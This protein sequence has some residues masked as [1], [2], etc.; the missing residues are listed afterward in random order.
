LNVFPIQLPAL[1]DRPEDVP[2]LVRYLVE[3]CAEK[4]GKKI[5]TIDEQTLDLLRAYDWPG[6][7]RE[8]QNVI[9]RAVIL[10]DGD[11]F[12]VEEAWLRG[13]AGTGDIESRIP[14][15]NAGASQERLRI[16]AALAASQGTVSGPTGAAA[17]LGIPR[18][19][20]ES[21]IRVLH[22]NK[23]RFKAL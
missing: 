23:Y 11:V 8:L 19:T 5:N 14:P 15:R 6:N 12:S 4:A 20:L 13:N 3:R 16:E 21:R 17:R 9:E 2:S 7:V 22:I 10:A 18:Q 1:R